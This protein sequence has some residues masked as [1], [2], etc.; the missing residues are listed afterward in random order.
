LHGKGWLERGGIMPLRSILQICVVCPLGNHLDCLVF[1]DFPQSRARRS[2]ET[3]RKALF[4][5]KPPQKD[6]E[7]Q[8]ERPIG[9]SNIPSPFNPS[10]SLSSGMDCFSSILLICTNSGLVVGD[11]PNP[12]T[13]CPHFTGNRK[14]EPTLRS[15]RSFPGA[16]MDRSFARTDGAI[17]RV[18]PVGSGAPVRSRTTRP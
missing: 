17:L 1:I 12:E 7:E 13:V 6:P 16:S 9:R 5:G 4:D 18:P 2:I 10:A 11:K 3:G 15:R 14:P 8:T